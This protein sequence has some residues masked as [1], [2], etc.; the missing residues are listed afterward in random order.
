MV[1]RAVSPTS[2]ATSTRLAATTMCSLYRRGASIGKEREFGICR[3]DGARQGAALLPVL[4]RS[5][6]LPRA[7][8]KL[9][10]EQTCHSRRA[11]VEL[12]RGAQGS[13]RHGRASRRSRL[14]IE[15][16]ALRSGDG[17]DQAHADR[18]AG[19]DRAR[20]DETLPD[21]GGHGKRTK[22]FALSGLTASSYN[23]GA[24]DE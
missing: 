23:E 13:H 7:L 2:A 21:G 8:R 12:C 3:T 15:H 24:T 9:H 17:R 19:R 5:S 10:H 11:T 4:R 14:R 22:S 18:A 20:A 1:A 6:P 16:P